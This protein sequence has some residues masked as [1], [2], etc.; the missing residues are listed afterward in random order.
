MNRAAAAIARREA[1]TAAA[2]TPDKPRFVA[3]VVGPTGR[4]LS[5]SPDIDD[6]GLRL[7][8]FEEMATIY[9]EA[10]RGL[11]DGGADIILVETVF[12]TLNCKAA[13]VA[14]ARIFDERACALP[15][16]ISGTITDLSGR[17]LSGI[18]HALRAA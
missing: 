13:L 18:R 11:I 2:R 8:T 14:L 5:V 16:M 3:G 6:P 9:A 15:I 7:M 4:M 12:D 17:T 10:A 1:D